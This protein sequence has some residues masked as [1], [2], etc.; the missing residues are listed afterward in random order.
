MMIGNGMD[1][2]WYDYEKYG[3]T[4]NERQCSKLI[5]GCT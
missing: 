3:Y 5:G 2:L 1:A 4:D